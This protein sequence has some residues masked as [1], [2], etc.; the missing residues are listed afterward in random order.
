[1]AGRTASR[2][3]EIW[4]DTSSGASSAAAPVSYLAE[5]SLDQTTDTI[6]V[7]SF[8]DTTKT[9]VT[10]LPDAQGSMS[11]F[12]N[13]GTATF[14][15]LADGN[16]RKTYVYMTSDRTEYFFGTCR[17]SASYQGSVGGA[18][19]VSLNWVAATPVSWVGSV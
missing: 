10:G 6:E 14:K 11:G 13:I 12:L 8:G 16:A 3:A 4:C 7:T 2:T 15:Y 1:M 19:Q 17:Y 9:Y 18:L 5:W